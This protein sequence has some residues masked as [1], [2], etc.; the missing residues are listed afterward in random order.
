MAKG[1]GG[2]DTAQFFSPGTGAGG[3]IGQVNAPSG[4]PLDQMTASMGV[5]GKGMEA[6]TTARLNRDKMAMEKEKFSQDMSYKQA[7]LDL[8]REDNQLNAIKYASAMKQQ[9]FD[10]QM[11]MEQNQRAEIKTQLEVTDWKNKEEVANI[12]RQNIPTIT[13]VLENGTYQDLMASDEYQTMLSGLAVVD[14]EGAVKQVNTIYKEIAKEKQDKKAIATY[15]MTESLYVEELPNV[16]AALDGG[17]PMNEAIEPI[18]QKLAALYKSGNIDHKAVTEQL[19]GIMSMLKSYKS[20]SGPTSLVSFDAQGNQVDPLMNPGA[21]AR[22]VDPRTSKITTPGGSNKKKSLVEELQEM[23][24]M[25]EQ[26]KKG[27]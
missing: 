1:F 17:K 21:V 12:F 8:N 14:P 26:N 6:F 13:K 19:K 23:K 2:A 20:K 27:K 22:Q 7:Q 10:N 9:E 25:Q 4:D 15:G 3:Y 16:M 5:L 18:R 11:K 24:A